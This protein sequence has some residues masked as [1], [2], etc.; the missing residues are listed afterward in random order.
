M[1][2][3]KLILNSEKKHLLVMTSARNHLNHQNFGI[4]LDTGTEIIEPGHEERLLG[5]IISNDMKWNSHVRDSE[6]SLTTIL[7]S[8]INALC[9]VSAYSS[10]KTGKMIANGVMMSHITYLIQLYGG[11]SEQ[12]LSSLQVLQNKAARLVTKLDWRTPTRTLL[13]QCG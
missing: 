8:R 10:F 9:K 12:L 11:C 1:T 13:L 5:G 3:N 2:K 7:T 4:T 6:K